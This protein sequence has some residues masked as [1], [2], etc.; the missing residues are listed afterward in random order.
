M[1]SG[2]ARQLERAYVIAPRLARRERQRDGNSHNGRVCDHGDGSILRMP[3]PAAACRRFRP[4]AFGAMLRDRAPSR[5]PLPIR[6]ALATAR[7]ARASAS[8]PASCRT[9]PWV[10]K[11]KRLQRARAEA[12]ADRRS[13]QDDSLQPVAQHARQ[14]IALVG[15]LDPIEAFASRRVLQMLEHDFHAAHLGLPPAQVRDQAGR[16]CARPPP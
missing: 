16:A 14:T 6:D 9:N 8:R 12:Q 10:V 2:P 1:R 5:T 15:R 7:A 4:C 13:G 11:H 3:P